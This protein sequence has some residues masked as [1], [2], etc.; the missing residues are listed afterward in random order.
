MLYWAKKLS[1]LNFD[2]LMQLYQEGNQENALELYGQMEPAK[3]L[4]RAEQDF[5]DYLT[6]DFFTHKD[7]RYA[8]WVQDDHYVSALRLEPWQDGLLLEA[9]ETHPNFRRQGFAKALI[10]EMQ[11]SLRGVAVYSHVSKRNKASLAVHK[12]CGFVIC[13]DSVRLLDGTVSSSGVTLR[14]YPEKEGRVEE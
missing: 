2:S 11:K 7:A 12:A 3:A 13:K 5:V 4:A 10:C 1:E 14:W 6:E 9:L 8:I